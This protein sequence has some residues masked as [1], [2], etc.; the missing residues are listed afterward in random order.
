MLRAELSTLLHCQ[1][2]DAIEAEDAYGR[3]MIL[4]SSILAFTPLVFF[5]SF[6]KDW[7]FSRLIF[8]SAARHAAACLF[9]DFA[10]LLLLHDYFRAIRLLPSA[11]VFS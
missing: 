3:H 9:A 8:S 4:L 2:A 6:E 7:P 10:T 11:E 5:F 1:P